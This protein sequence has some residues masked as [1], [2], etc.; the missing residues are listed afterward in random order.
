MKDEVIL[1][2]KNLTKYFPGVKALDNI[3][4]NI[5]KG[6]V[7]ALLGE[8]GAGKSTLVKIVSGAISRDSGEIYFDG[9]K[10]EFASPREAHKVGISV[11]YQ[12]TSLIPQ[13]TVIQNIFLGIEY[14]K[15]FLNIIDN[16]K[17]VKEYNNVCNDIGFSF[18]KNEPVKNLGVAEQKMVEILKALVHKAQFVIMDEP[19]DSL[20]ESEKNHLFRIIL[21]LKKKNITVLYITH[22]LE[23]V[24]K[25]TDRITILRDGRKVDTVLTES[26]NK[27]DIIKMMV[28]HEFVDALP[29]MAKK[30]YKK[31]ALRVENIN[32]KGVIKNVSFT[33]YYGEILGITGLIGAGKTELARLLFGANKIDT[34]SIYINKKLC[35]I[36]S[37]ID[38]IKDKICMLPEDKKADGLI[39]KH[40]VYKN[41]T[42][43]ALDRFINKMVLLKTEELKVTS[44]MAEKL[45][46]KISNAYQ[47][48]R[49]LSG[50]N[51]QK[52][53]IAK[54]LTARPEILIL[55]EPTRGIDIGTKHEVYKIIRNLAEDG[56][57]VIFMSSE[58]SE[59]A[60]VCDRILILKKGTV[61]AEFMHGVMQKE[62]M[63][64]II[65][66]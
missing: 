13:L 39:L 2:I 16:K 44:E 66:D 6:E 23:E 24:F 5:E 20:S 38:A 35:R 42:L 62:I 54:W 17:I 60:K 48:V 46:I 29:T 40:E 55:D 37:P 45:G 52:V 22:L 61:T 53:I 63:Q 47:S 58:V 30:R 25:I 33:A 34:G 51:Q 3:D 10:K 57:C 8:N 64:T 12:E 18:P 31:E 32:K 9:I 50:G 7:H 4:L 59:I 43:S 26:V 15:T 41:I 36:N 1:E 27:G 49:T 11:I 19:T 28:G 21:E 56:A 65:E 14:F